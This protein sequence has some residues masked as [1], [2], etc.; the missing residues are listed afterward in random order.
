MEEL[1]QKGY[2]VLGPKES[3]SIS[4]CIMLYYEPTEHQK[5]NMMEMFGWEFVT[6]QE[7]EE[8]LKHRDNHE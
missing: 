1:E 5:R 3:I 4:A 7:A 8:L 6:L 2:L